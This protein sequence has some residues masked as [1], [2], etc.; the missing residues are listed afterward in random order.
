[1]VRAFS[2]WAALMLC[3]VFVGNPVRAF[4][5]WAALGR[6]PPSSTALAGSRSLGHGQDEALGAAQALEGDKVLAER[7]VTA[8][9]SA[10]AVTSG[11]ASLA[12]RDVA[13]TP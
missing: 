3:L 11:R 9:G 2:P 8:S 4:S 13:T 5:P 1:M 7:F 6:A 12:K 10:G